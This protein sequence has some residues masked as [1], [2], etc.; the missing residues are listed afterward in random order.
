MTKIRDYQHDLIE[1]LCDPREAAEY[2]YAALEDGDCVVVTNALRNVIEALALPA[3]GEE[4]ETL[5]RL[6]GYLGTAGLRLTIS[7]R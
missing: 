2:L 7:P 3:H 1:D 5:C 4:A 6:K